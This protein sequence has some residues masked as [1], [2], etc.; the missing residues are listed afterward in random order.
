[1]TYQTSW[2]P[3]KY[4]TYQRDYQ[5]K[6]KQVPPERWYISDDPLPRKVRMAGCSSIEEYLEKTKIKRTECTCGIHVRDTEKSR[7]R[8]LSTKNHE[9]FLKRKLLQLEKS[10]TSKIDE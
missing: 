7:S 4:R 8:H 6:M 3:E 9:L 2:T 10:E 1:M 5:R